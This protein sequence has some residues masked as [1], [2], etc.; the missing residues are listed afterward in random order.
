VNADNISTWW[1]S[2]SGGQAPYTSVWSVDG[3][4]MQRGTND[5]F[6]Y[7]SG[8]DFTVSLTVIDGSGTSSSPSDLYVMVQNCG[9]AFYC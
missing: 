6:A 5:H 1:A 8:W 7:S 3:G 4:E 9:G 2:V